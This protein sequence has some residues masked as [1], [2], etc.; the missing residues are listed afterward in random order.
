MTTYR[1]EPATDDAYELGEGPVW[2]PERER[3]L[4]VDIE[5][6]RIHTGSLEAGGGGGPARIAPTTTHETGG[7]VGAVVV[8]PG[9]RL[10]YAGH[11]ALAV[12]EPDGSVT[13]GPAVVPGVAGQRLNDGKCDPAGR[14]LVGSLTLPQVS[15]DDVLVRLE[16][17]GGLVALD[18]DLSLSNGLAWSPAGTELYSI[19]THTALVHVRDYDTGSGLFG[20]HRVAFGVEADGGPDG[21]AA[22]AEGNLWIAVFGAGEVRCYSPSGAWLHTVEVAAP[23]VT[24]VAFAGPGL[25]VLVVTTAYTGLDDA[26]REAA[27]GSGRLFTAQVGVPGVPVAGWNG[28]GL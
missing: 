7:T 3:L 4:W 19:D 5:A 26:A 17:T 16:D 10:L 1:A 14:F 28:L 9:G 2:D 6:G 22:D 8:G 27:P 20:P 23:R 25:D 11:T 24:S 15:G 13:A 18:E 12:L 21:M